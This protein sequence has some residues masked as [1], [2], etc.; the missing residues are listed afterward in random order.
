MAFQVHSDGH[1]LIGHINDHVYAAPEGCSRDDGPEREDPESKG[2]KSQVG[3][4]RT[5]N[6]SPPSLGGLGTESSLVELTVTATDDSWREHGVP[7]DTGWCKA[8]RPGWSRTDSHCHSWGR[9]SGRTSTSGSSRTSTWRSSSRQWHLSWGAWSSRP[10]V[11]PNDRRSGVSSPFHGPLRPRR[12]FPTSWVFPVRDQTSTLTPTPTT[13]FSPG[14]VLSAPED[15]IGTLGPLVLL[16]VPDSDRVDVCRVVDGGRRSGP[17]LER[18]RGGG[19]V[20]LFISVDGRRRLRL[21]RLRL[22][23]RGP[24]RPADTRLGV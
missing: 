4:V 9:R 3:M 5:S 16:P 6:P 1:P 20:E 23:G 14:P 15:R 24:L 17:E 7:C 13:P 22:P 8:G 12:H 11:G 21:P 18:H 19:S 10:R 2:W